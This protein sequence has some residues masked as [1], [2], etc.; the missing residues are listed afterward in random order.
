[1][2]DTA[3]EPDGLFNDAVMVEIAK[4]AKA[5]DD[6]VAISILQTKLRSIGEEYRRVI[7][8]TP[9]SL[10]G[11]PSSHTLSQRL[12]WVDAKL[13]NPID[14]LLE[15]LDPENRHMLTLWPEEPSPELI[16]DY[17]NIAEQ[18]RNLKLL[19]QNLAIIL[20]KYRH[21]DLQPGPMIWYNIV[22]AIAAALDETLP[23]LRASR[24]TFDRKAKRYYGRYPEVVRR[25]FQEITGAYEQLD[26]LIKEQVDERR[27]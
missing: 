24:G 6:H 2:K 8:I 19:G 16:P 25:I 5:D 12:D 22:A 11:A 18:L 4:L 26:A 27:K 13:L 21:Y 7:S 23:K 10:R 15:A 9:S 20:A 1:L 14:R 3:N 17:D